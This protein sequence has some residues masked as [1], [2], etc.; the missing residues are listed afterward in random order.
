MQQKQHLQGLV[1]KE[2]EIGKW[3]STKDDFIQNISA[4]EIVKLVAKVG[5]LDGALVHCVLESILHTLKAYLVGDYNSW[6]N[7]L[8]AV[9]AIPQDYL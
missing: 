5:D 7:F 2:S 6:D 1:L 4:E 3:H 9:Y 8:K